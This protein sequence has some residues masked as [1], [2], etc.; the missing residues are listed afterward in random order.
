MRYLMPGW[1]GMAVIAHTL[2][3]DLTVLDGTQSGRPL[4]V[5]RWSGLTAPTRVTVGSKSEAFFHTGAQSL[6]EQLPA[7]TYGTLEG[8]GHGA[9]LMAPKALADTLYQFFCE[10]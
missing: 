8:K 10:S 9:V 4:P 3:Y 5:E 7:V 2:P 1:S 6:A